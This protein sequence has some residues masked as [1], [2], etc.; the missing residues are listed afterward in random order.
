MA[1]VEYFAHFCA[2][3]FLCNCIPH[4]VAG[5]QGRAFP[6]PFATP[7][8]IGDSSPLINFLW[9]LS[10]LVA[11]GAW[12]V[13]YPFHVGINAGT[14]FLLCGVLALGTYLAVHFGHVRAGAVRKN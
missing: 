1:V 11:G 2:G 6:T 10:N 14:L 9:G 7:R 13:N 4:L 12:L 8:G 5:L 3:L